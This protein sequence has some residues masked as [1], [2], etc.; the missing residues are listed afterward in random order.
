MPPLK[1]SEK[2]V[3]DTV[4]IERVEKHSSGSMTITTLIG[5]VRI[6]SLIEMKR[7]ILQLY[8]LSVTTPYTLKGI[9]DLINSLKLLQASEERIK[10][11]VRF[12]K[13][14]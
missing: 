12:I 14:S 2:E 1:K 6:E 13:T 3:K 8:V 4:R 10:R 9:P 5:G 11:W 7:G